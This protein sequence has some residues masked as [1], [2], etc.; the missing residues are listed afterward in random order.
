MT[1]LDLL[2]NAC[3]HL[4]WVAP[5]LARRLSRI[6]SAALSAIICVDKAACEAVDESV[7]VLAE[8]ESALLT[9][10]PIEA[11]ERREAERMEREAE[12]EQAAAWKGIN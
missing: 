11:E 10:C 6:V 4:S 1:R 3:T 2:T 12:R 5:V 9:H 8:V 7:H